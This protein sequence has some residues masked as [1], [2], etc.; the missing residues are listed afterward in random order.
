MGTRNTVRTLNTLLFKDSSGHGPPGREIVCVP[1]LT[2]LRRSLLTFCDRDRGQVIITDETLPSA[3]KGDTFLPR[4]RLS[5]FNIYLWFRAENLSR[6]ARLTVTRDFLP[7]DL[8]NER[9]FER[10]S[11]TIGRGSRLTNRVGPFSRLSRVA[12]SPGR[13]EDGNG[14]VL[15][16]PGDRSPLLTIDCPWNKQ[17]SR[18]EREWRSNRVAEREVRS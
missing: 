17:D 9:F 8:D 13:Q 1:A 4:L 3:Y 12:A 11:E 2:R 15:S 5:R 7:R 6:L 18:S 14:T 10:P 16:L